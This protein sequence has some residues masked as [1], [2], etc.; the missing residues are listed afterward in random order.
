MGQQRWNATQSDHQTEQQTADLP[1]PTLTTTSS[2][3]TARTASTAGPASS[4]RSVA[5]W[6]QPE[7]LSTPES[8]G[9]I[10]DTNAN[11]RTGQVDLSSAVA[12]RSRGR[13][14]GERVHSA[15]LG[16]RFRQVGLDGVAQARA[17]LA[18]AARRANERNAA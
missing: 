13:G 18:E 6:Q 11:A 15:K 3:R 17:A 14:V 8:S 4:A 2:A 12:H 16:E 5:T 1:I 9:N 10:D 7:L